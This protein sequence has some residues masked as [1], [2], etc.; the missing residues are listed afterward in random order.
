MWGVTWYP[1]PLPQHPV[2][3]LRASVLTFRSTPLPRASR[4]GLTQR[5][6]LVLTAA[7]LLSACGGSKGDSPV[8]PVTPV[9]TSIAVQ[10]GDNQS[11]SAGSALAVVPSV[12]VRDQQARPMAGVAVAFRVDSGGGAITNASVT[13][14]ADGVASA[15][16]W[17]IGTGRNRLRATAGTLAPVFFTATSTTEVVAATGTISPAGGSVTVTTAGSPLL[18]TVVTVP[19]GLVTTPFTLSISA[20]DSSGIPTRP[21]VRIASPVITIS[22]STAL[23]DSLAPLRITVPAATSAT[24]YPIA[25][26]FN[27][28]TGTMIPLPTIRVSA[29][30][31]TTVA[32]HVNG[33]RL[34]GTAPAPRIIGK[35]TGPSLSVADTPGFIQLVIGAIAYSDLAADITTG[36]T[37]GV[38]DWE[39]DNMLTT[40]GTANIAQRQLGLAATAAWYFD[41]FRVSR[42]TLSGRYQEAPGVELSNPR[43]VAIS[44]LAAQE[45]N[46]KGVE[47]YYRA[48]DALR[49][50][51]NQPSVTLD[52]LTL[53]AVKAGMFATGKPYVLMAIDT[54]A[55]DSTAA[56]LVVYSTRG[57]T[58]NFSTGTAAAG[59]NG[60]KALTLS[61]GRF[62]S[63]AWGLKNPETGASLT[64]TLP[65]IVLTG[66]STGLSADRLNA[67]WGSVFDNTITKIG[68]PTFEIASRDYRPVR[69]TF[70]VANDSAQL[71]LECT[72][73][74]CETGY[75]VTG[76]F[77]PVNNVASGGLYTRRAGTWVN[78]GTAIRGRGIWAADRDDG[79]VAGLTLLSRA[80]DTQAL[81]GG[82]RQFVI[83]TKRLVITPTPLQPIAG[84]DFT[85][86]ATY[87]RTLPPSPSWVWE[88]G[89]GR[90]LTTTTN[91]LT[92]KYGSVAA[93]TSYVVKVSLKGGTTL[94]ATGRSVATV[95]PP[96]F[97]WALRS[98][99]VQS[100]T[101]PQGGIGNLKSDTT[102]FNY[103]T[104]V[105]AS[106]TGTPGNSAL[107]VA[108]VANGGP[109]CDAG[110]IL[111]QAPSAGAIADTLVGN[112]FV[113]LL[114]VCNDPDYTGNL[115]MGTLGAGTI[116]GNAVVIPNDDVIVAPGGSINA[117]MSAKNLGG[118]FVWNVRYSTGLA[119]YTV[120]FTAVQVRPQ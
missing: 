95:N 91:T 34:D 29:T 24:E 60:P 7:V 88:L 61:N 67:L 103:A 28:V 1:A 69:D 44:R 9:A 109:S 8:T 6:L 54:T 55:S 93:P 52:S 56:S 12:I 82:W 100:S 3:P 113:G 87:S 15:G 4:T 46:W 63:V 32:R 106:L 11:A 47:G 86:T 25:M 101:L 35:G 111:Q 98:A 14:G 31:V 26:L 119:T 57:S 107:F 117:T 84:V 27:R 33:A 102:I 10:A 108:G 97:G 38:D 116:V 23:P 114:G 76:G 18:G 65:T 43:G 92:T 37:P 70:F 48:L 77:T 90:T 16:N 85:M 74:G 68:S 49:A 2:V 41:K 94:E 96:L 21:R 120:T 64:A 17:T 50:S 112:Q 105:I 81:Y 79:V 118:T 39:F 75:P 83:K 45:F 71:W 5:R 99:T 13:T 73:T 89:D 72:G 78:A 51:A 53:L 115:T 36:Y 59:V 22:T 58:L 42:G 20:G 110:A 30:Q 62:N 19:S 66:L 40:F 80:S 104:G